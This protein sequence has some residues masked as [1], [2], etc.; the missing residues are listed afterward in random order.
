MPDL[1]FCGTGVLIFD[2]EAFRMDIEIENL[3]EFP[4]VLNKYGTPIVKIIARK[5]KRGKGWY[6]AK[7]DWAYDRHEQY[8]DQG[9]EQPRQQPQSQRKREQA[10]NPLAYNAPPPQD[11]P[12]PFPDAN[13]DID[14]FGA[15]DSKNI[16]DVPF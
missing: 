10:G 14:D 8:R 4:I 13:D 3:K 5:K 16:D 15:D 2:G 9:Q 11:N 1:K 12:P 7:D 6:I